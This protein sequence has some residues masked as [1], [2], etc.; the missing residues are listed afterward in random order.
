MLPLGS[1]FMVAAPGVQPAGHTSPCLSTCCAREQQDAQ[2]G[3]NRQR[4]YMHTRCA[5]CISHAARRRACARGTHLE[6]LDEA[7]HLVDGAADGQ[8]VHRDLAQ[9]ASL[10]DDEQAAAQAGH[11]GVG[12]RAA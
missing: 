2:T 5:A 1:A 11:E 6:G 10:V 4:A 8:V 12:T 9:H 7:Q 3:S